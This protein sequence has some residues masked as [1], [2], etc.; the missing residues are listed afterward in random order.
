[1]HIHVSSTNGEAKFW[2][3]PTIALE[4]NYGLSPEAITEILTIIEERKDE[5]IDSWKRHFQP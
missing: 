2:L 4:K 1:M 3:E 5:I